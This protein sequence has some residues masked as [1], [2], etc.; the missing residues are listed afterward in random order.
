MISGA[1]KDAKFM[2]FMY[3]T[4]MGWQKAVRPGR[5]QEVGTVEGAVGKAGSPETE[6]GQTG[7]KGSGAVGAGAT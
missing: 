5:R 4:R 7:Q 3:F 2:T 1:M 6:S